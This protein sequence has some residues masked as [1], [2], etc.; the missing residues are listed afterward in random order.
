MAESPPNEVEV[1]GSF[2]VSLQL[3]ADYRFLVDFGLEGVEE[4]AT[5]EPPPELFLANLDDDMG[6]TTN[7][8]DQH[9]EVTTDLK[10]LAEEWRGRIERRWEEEYGAPSEEQRVVGFSGSKDI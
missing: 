10:A 9:P 3:Q 1:V 5:D 8:A 6:E 7:L 2:D 4:L